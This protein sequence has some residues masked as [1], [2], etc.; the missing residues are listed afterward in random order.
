MFLHF[1]ST[2]GPQGQNVHMI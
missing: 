2:Q 1:L